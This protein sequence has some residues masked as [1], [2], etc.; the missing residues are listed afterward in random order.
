MT[1]DGSII[2]EPFE[3]FE[4]TDSQREILSR[5]LAQRAAK[6][7]AETQELLAGLKRLRARF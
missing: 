1:D 7:E 2:S 3:N 4:L 5:A 6:L